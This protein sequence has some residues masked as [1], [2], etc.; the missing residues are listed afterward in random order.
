MIGFEDV[1]GYFRWLWFAI[2]WVK[3]AHWVRW[4]CYFTSRTVAITVPLPYPFPPKINCKQN[5]V[6]FC[7]HVKYF[8]Y[9]LYSWWC[10]SRAKYIEFFKT[11]VVSICNIAIPYFVLTSCRTMPSVFTH[12]FVNIFHQVISPLLVSQIEE[13]N[14]NRI[15][16]IPNMKRFLWN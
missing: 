14:W 2:S 13:L 7:P 4:T 6:T 3:N 1:F 9:S 16:S 12:N 11:R 10:T 15:Y 8:S 5:Y